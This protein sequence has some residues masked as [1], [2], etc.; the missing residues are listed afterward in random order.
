MSIYQSYVYDTLFF[1][2]NKEQ[3]DQSIQ[4]LKD[5]GVSVE[6]EDSVAGFLSVH[7]GKQ[8]E[9]IKLT[10]KG[11]CKRIIEALH[12]TSLP[13]KHT[14]A[15]KDLLGKDPDG[16]PPNGQYS[17]PL[18]IGML[19]YLCGHSRPDL[20]F[21]VSQCARFIHGTKRSH[22]VALERIGQYLKGTMEEVLVLKLNVSMDIEC[23]VDADF[24]GLFAF[25][26]VLDPSCVKSRT[27][28]IIRVSGCPII[29]TSRLQTD[30]A[31]STM[32]SEYNSLSMAMKELLPFQ[33]LFKEVF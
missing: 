9:S 22:E 25:E 5:S 8:K 2:P 28:Y 11:L 3:I 26:D 12:V 17:Y 7:I 13:I 14:P 29:W 6:I 1:S 30:I 27:G 33:D 32:E 18:V 15:A 21:A 19:L 16:D 23:F 24:A 10:Q 31:S 4:S 20:Q